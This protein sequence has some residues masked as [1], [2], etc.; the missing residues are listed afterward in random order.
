MKKCAKRIL[1]ALLS[2]SMAVS[3]WTPAITAEAATQLVNVAPLGTAVTSSGENGDHV[4]A[5]VND[6]DDTTSWQT[7]G[8]WPSTAVVQL[9]QG[10]TVSEVVVKLGEKNDNSAGRTA[11][12]TVQYAQNG[13]TSN[14]INI[15]SYRM[16][17]DSDYTFKLSTPISATHIYVT[18]SEP[19]TAEGTTG[20]FWPSV[21]EIEVYEEQETAAISAY[22][23]IANQAVI[24]TTGSEHPTDGSSNLVDGSDSTLYK[25]HNAAM[26]SEKEIVLTYAEARAMNA[27]RIEFENVGASDSIDFAFSYSILAKNGD[28]VYDTIVAN[29]AANRTNN[30]SQEYKFTEKTYSEVKIV[31]HSC[32]TYGGSSAGWPAIAEFEVY[33]S[34]VVV[35][36]EANI[37]L[38]KPVHVSS[39]KTL[40]RNIT[41]GSVNSTWRG[42]YYPAYVDINLEKNYNLDTVEVFTPENGY[43]Q[44]TIYTSMDGR[45]F[46]KLAEKTSKDSATLAAGE[47]YQAD[48]KEAR[49]VRVYLEY[50]SAETAAV[51]NEVR[52]TGTE[53]NT[54]IQER[55]AVN[56]KK[57]SESAYADTLTVTA[58]DTYAEV[59]GMAETEKEVTLK[60]GESI[61]FLDVSGTY[62]PD[63]LKDL[64]SSIAT[65][66]VGA[67]TFNDTVAKLFN[68]NTEDTVSALERYTGNLISLSDCIY[69]FEKA[70]EDT[71]YIYGAAE[72]GEKVYLNVSD[73][74]N[75]VGCPNTTT[76]EVTKVTKVTSQTGVVEGFAFQD[77]NINNSNGNTYTL[78][79]IK[80]WGVF[81]ESTTD[82]N[83]QKLTTFKV[84]ELSKEENGSYVYKDVTEIQ[85]GGSYVIVAAFDSDANGTLDVEYVL[86]PSAS[87]TGTKR[88]DHVAL[89]SNATS[90]VQGSEVSITGVSAGTT[91]V[92]VGTTKYNVH[93][94]AEKHVPVR[95]G[96]TVRIF[97]Q[98]GAFKESGL[99]TLDTTKATVTVETTAIEEKV[100]K[101]YNGTSY[102]GAAID[103]N[104]CLYTFNKN[105]DG[106]YVIVAVT[107]DGKTVYLNPYTGTNQ[108]VRGFP[109][110]ETPENITIVEGE[111]G[112]SFLES[113]KK[114]TG[115]QENY[116]LTFVNGWKVFNENPSADNG[117]ANETTTTEFKVYQAVKSGD[118]YVY[119]EV[120]S[121]SEIQDGAQYY[122]AASVSDVE[123]VLRPSAST[124]DRNAHVAKVAEVKDDLVSGNEMHISG[125]SVGDTEVTVGN[126]VY[127]IHVVAN[128]QNI[129]VR[130]GQ[131]IILEGSVV[132]QN[133]DKQYAIIE[134]V[135]GADSYKLT[136][137]TKGETE[138]VLDDVIY[139]VK[140]VE[141]EIAS[142]VGRSDG[143]VVKR[144]TMSANNTFDLCVIN[145]ESAVANWKV[146]DKETG[147]NAEWANVDANGR[148]AAANSSDNK[149][150][151]GYIVAELSDGKTIKIEFKLTP[152]PTVEHIRLYDIYV[153]KLYHTDVWYGWLYER[154]N[155][156]GENTSEYT[157]LAQV[158]EGEVIYVSVGYAFGTAIDFF[159][160]PENG[161]ALT[162]MKATDTQGHY[163]R[164]AGSTPEETEFVATESV[165]GYVQYHNIGED[166]TRELVQ[167]AM[168]IGCHGAQGFTKLAN[169]SGNLETILNYRSEKLPTVTKTTIGVS[170]PGGYKDNYR[171][172]NEKVKVQIGDYV[173][174]K[175][176]VNTYECEDLITYNKVMLEDLL[177]GAVFV[178]KE[179][180]G[181]SE[182]SDAKIEN[183][184]DITTEIDADSYEAKTHDYYVKYQIQ[185][186]DIASVSH[187]VVNTAEL[188]YEYSTT[189]SNGVF[190]SDAKDNA[191]VMI[192]DIPLNSIVVD[193]GLPVTYKFDD[194]TKYELE[195]DETS[196]GNVTLDVTEGDGK[197]DYVLT[198]TASETL[199]G[200]DTISLKI[201]ET[202]SANEK[203]GDIKVVGV[204][205]ATTV[206]YEEN[207]MTADVAGQWKFSEVFDELQETAHPG[208]T[209]SETP[210][211]NY[212]YDAAYAEEVI[213]EAVSQIT[214]AEINDAKEKVLSRDAIKNVRAS[215]EEN[216]TNDVENAF[217]GNPG[218]I[219][220][221][222]WGNPGKLANHPNGIDV[223]ITLTKETVISKLSY[224]PRLDVPNGGT[225]GQYEIY[226]ATEVDGEGNPL[227]GEEP[228][229][230]GIFELVGSEERYQDVVFETPV[231]AKYLRLKTVSMAGGEHPTA[232]E[233]KIYEAVKNATVKEEAT[234]TFKGTGVDVFANCDA[235]TGIVMVMVKD[236]DG[237]LKKM[238][239]VD[240]KLN[241]G[242]ID[243]SEEHAAA[244]GSETT[245]IPIVSIPA[246]GLAYGD[247]EVQ[248]IHTSKKVTTTDAQGV[249]STE[250][251]PT[252]LRID[253]FRVY[254]T[255]EA[256][257]ATKIHAQDNENAPVYYDMKDSVMAG[258]SINGE[259][260]I[261]K[262][263]LQNLLSQVYA[264]DAEKVSGAMLVAA[265]TEN[266]AYTTDA[267]KKDFLD[268]TS[269]NELYVYPGQSL[270]FA[271]GASVN[272]PQ[273]AI[274]ALN[275]T[276]NYTIAKKEAGNSSASTVTTAKELSANTEMYYV[277][278]MLTDANAQQL[279]TSFTITNTGTTA[280]SITKLKVP[281]ANTA[282]AAKAFIELTEADFTA[283]LAMFDAEVPGGD[284]EELPQEAVVSRIAG[285]DRYETAFKV[286]DAL[287]ET[288]GVDKFE[289]VV[290]ATGKNFADALSGSYLA[291]VK[292]AP[293]LLT[294]EKHTAELVEYVKANLSENGTVYI[295]GGAAAVPE[296]VENDLKAYAVKRLA[297]ATR[298]ETN[299]A[300]LNEVGLVNEPGMGQRVLL[301]ATGTGFAD[302]LSA[303]ATKKPILLVKDKITEAHKE[304]LRMYDG[305]KIY[306]IGGTGVVS[307]EVQNALVG[308]GRI[309]RLAG[310]T[311]YE[312]S[313]K[314]AETFFPE[315]QSAVLAYAKEFPD[316]LA[317]GTLA[318]AMGA[319]LI[320]T[321][322]GKTADAA[323]YMQT[324][325]I[326]S[327]IVLG[328][329]ARIS[330]EAVEE[331]F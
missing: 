275:G 305:S 123:Y 205:P 288:L 259:N 309:F 16:T 250:I 39:G 118:K 269:K 330:D 121:L 107:E 301:I 50:N 43:S 146:I 105:A 207:F 306:I 48:G 139:H 290:V 219:W 184:M 45:D 19:Q 171:E 131:S 168:D 26:S 191:E 176:T 257:Y 238:Y 216:G 235:N 174:F 93:V 291:T 143:M 18:L 138:F 274:K 220:H 160:R 231:K 186:K 271:L 61:S 256:E 156:D 165:A 68:Y 179:S 106:T 328:G 197:Y 183:V 97:D 76:E 21:E 242:A 316:G 293:I 27:V 319:P 194:L 228:V 104:S 154:D 282:G 24:T 166:A 34:E 74:A 35:V 100:A 185:A 56:V 52:V 241:L 114:T 261:Y 37:A 264:T 25:F 304:I 320:L 103:L 66:N 101:L 322:D 190:S 12:V 177:E 122:I 303:S 297:G 126:T 117:G 229:H 295:L 318:A 13:V 172:Y 258:M 323:A 302:S 79:F 272:N 1:A 60:V 124:D 91:S 173:Y 20:S 239:T 218:T 62:N 222:Q 110:K 46:Y 201:V 125:I 227:Y 236:S 73:S 102:D 4:I 196:Y 240:T 192:L 308:H 108:A 199:K 155:P 206:Y 244:L 30:S 31:M 95:T 326:Q 298:Y 209:T 142:S 59:G 182:L 296:T 87:N 44:Y 134:K 7:Q 109:S 98:S 214:E 265:G 159:A 224:L 237:A 153:D 148:V 116:R 149:E 70:G 255:L 90:E 161:Y 287:K 233:I 151:N 169:A 36:D 85:D 170:G 83:A 38:G 115:D 251:I 57:F 249:T 49:I 136:G 273:L 331:I 294:N 278:G 204:Y 5:N 163:K 28:G 42:S 33:G 213:T 99:A 178:E 92:L 77:M 152:A 41:D 223:D 147:E 81:N 158:L 327:G 234:F 111:N 307:E 232:A 53:S 243:G 67:K 3:A 69:V 245:N 300:I 150:H 268:N 266:K 130:K 311:R 63:G 72:N 267:L 313:V 9:D 221:A 14:L 132:T 215:S 135:D 162:Q 253:G 23:N 15:G 17:V 289:A 188:T 276:A 277:L 55:P 248:L 10:R 252:N 286:A 141:E 281:S 263:Q 88:N 279:A 284:G 202:S 262:D 310:A 71:Y 270:V 84:K 145:T 203:V 321:A 292:N 314:V 211:A 22:N 89:V 226:A 6:G 260:S 254:G 64:D 324:K 75:D 80:N 212:G 208:S 315:A 198:Y 317:G 247:Y 140:V 112:F 230:N 193:Y 120:N 246:N 137:I 29:A 144:L 8:V 217:D 51:I 54:A 2:L 195:S 299:I 280:I 175:V 283:A 78:Q 187:S 225:I 65:V 128:E 157:G 167:S 180:E 127:K 312:T 189:Y 200:V 47:V 96:E 325:E 32:T 86:R 133:P 40:A 164:L 82:S 119:T 329:T 285:T 181:Y 113:S 129:E 210:T 11:L 94:L 58:D